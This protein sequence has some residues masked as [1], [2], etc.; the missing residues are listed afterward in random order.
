MSSPGK[1]SVVTARPVAQHELNVTPMLDV[2]LVLLVIFMAAAVGVHHTMDASLPVPCAVI[3]NPGSDPIVLEVLPG[4]RFL[5]NKY[6]LRA[7]E[8]AARI[9]AVYEGRPEKILHV[10]GKAGVT[11]E[12][13]VNA[14]DVARGSGVRVIAL[15]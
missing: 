9:R 12:Q 3:C 4:S 2:L 5:L 14:M 1:S 15:P 10:S 13:V 7:N 11:Y 8:L 6:E